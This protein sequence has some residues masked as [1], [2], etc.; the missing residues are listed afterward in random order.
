MDMCALG[1]G[2]EAFK[3]DIGN[4][5]EDTVGNCMSTITEGL[6][7]DMNDLRSEVNALDSR[8]NEG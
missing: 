5:I 8:I 6:K 2:Q 1:T 7:S 3:S 4:I